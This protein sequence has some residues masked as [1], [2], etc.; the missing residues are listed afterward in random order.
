MNPSANLSVPGLRSEVEPSNMR[1]ALLTRLSQAQDNS[2]SLERQRQDGIARIER[3]GWAFDPTADIFE[4]VESG[5]DQSARRPELERLLK[6]LERYDVVVFWKLDRTFRSMQAFLDFLRRCERARVGLVS[7]RE[8]LDTTTPVGRLVAYILMAIAEME[9]SNISL[10]VRSANDFIARSGAFRGGRPPFG[11]RSQIV[12]HEGTRPIRRLFLDPEWAP[13]VRVM[14]DECLQ[15]HSLHEIARRLNEHPIEG[16]KDWTSS[17]IRNVL[18]NPVLIG[19]VVHRGQIVVDESGVP[20]TPHEPLVD[21]WTWSRLQAVLDS[22]SGPERTPRSRRDSLLRGIIR[23]G[24][25]GARMQ[26]SPASRGGAYCCRTGTTNR[27]R[28]QGNAVKPDALHALVLAQLFERLTPEVVAEARTVLERQRALNS[29]PNPAETRLAELRQALDLLEDDRRAGLYI[30]A[31]GTR[32]YRTQH[33]RILGEIER[34]HTRTQAAGAAAVPDL[35]CLG[36]LPVCDAWE[37]LEA[38]EQRTILRSV[39]DRVVIYRPQLAPGKKGNGPRFRPERAEIV[40]KDSLPGAVPL[41]AEPVAVGS[42]RLERPAA[43]QQG[44]VE[45][46]AATCPG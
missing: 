22:I 43:P 11:W 24:H 40:W 14:V 4:D 12:A 15:G 39:I 27:A 3:E 41:H 31:E 37:R 23:C 46:E 33:V 10:R 34:L 2:T 21:H 8:D 6:D 28:C 26:A 20:L 16:R 25:C 45:L 1:A 19:R 36:P 17:T 38:V 32:R 35:S 18:R 29:E 42:G 13:I 7:V 30:S 9:S 5:W 44:V